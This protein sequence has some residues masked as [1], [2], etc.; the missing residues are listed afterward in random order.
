[1]ESAG[2]DIAPNFD[3]YIEVAFGI[4]NSVG[5]AG[6]TAFHRLCALCPK[7]E[8]EKADKLFTDAIAKGK[9]GNGLGSVF[10]L[11][12]QAGVKLG[13]LKRFSQNPSTPP[14]YFRT[15]VRTYYTD[16][17]PKNE[18]LDNSLQK[19]PIS[20]GEFLR[21]TKGVGNVHAQGKSDDLPYEKEYSDIPECFDTYTWPSFL[22][23]ILDCGEDPAQR[24]LLF[25][26]SVAALGATVC[27]I[28]SFNYGHKSIYPC[29]QVFILAPAASGKGAINWIRHLVA[30][31]HKEKIRR[32]EAAMKQ[33]NAELLKWSN[34]GRQRD[35]ATR[36]ERPKLELFFIAG[37]N[38]GTG[39][40]ENLID[41]DGLGFI[42][43]PEA[44]VLSSSIKAD[45]GQWSHL[46]RKAHDHE[47]LSYNRRKDHEYRECD[48][49]RLSVL[50]SGTPN[51][52]QQLIPGAENG[53]FSRQLFY[54]MQ[55][56]DDFKN[57]L[58]D[59]ATEDYAQLFFKWGSRWKRVID[60]IT[61]ATSSIRF[62]PSHTQ[63][64]LLHEH[65]SQLF[66]HAGAAHGGSMRSSVVR[67]AI[68]LLRVMNVVALLRALDALLM[69]EDE[70]GLKEKLNSIT[71]TLLNC[72]GIKPAAGTHAENVKDGVVTK[73]EL[74]I[75]D[76]DFAAVLHLAEPFYRHA[77]HAL[78]SMPMEALTE[79]S[80]SSKERF[81]SRLTLEFTRQE[82]IKMGSEEGLSDKQCD[83]MVEKLLNKN[84]LVRKGHGV[85]SFR[86]GKRPTDDELLSNFENISNN[87]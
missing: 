43:E 75:N 7:Y 16:Y 30:P 62:L 12:E 14:L 19:E 85:Y 73:F 63:A 27:K 28:S 48:L 17:T 8:A 2:V 54:Y 11:T 58:L 45:Y 9:G 60:A 32:F 5:E 22:Q 72:P 76:D 37:N 44:D 1:V 24:D 13:E 6:R 3:Q 40:Q 35:E 79:R 23:R 42:I 36:P 82:Y 84:I 77:E 20:E 31:F 69:E 46:L 34:M 50:I 78:F 49:I 83:Y 80:V 15:G 65:M 39:I 74:S 41:N 67:L 29:L 33:Y 10:Y 26:S 71:Y 86:G 64:E 47:Y 18:N 61:S 21:N 57:M 68:N 81:L 56:L 52:L 38:S 59:D 53:L 4:A 51:Q 25:V 87:P 66:R 70:E 55:P